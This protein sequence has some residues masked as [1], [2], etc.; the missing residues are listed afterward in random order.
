MSTVFMHFLKKILFA[1]I[2]INNYPLKIFILHKKMH[3]NA[4]KHQSYFL[5]II[6]EEQL[7]ETR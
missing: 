7:N 3:L 4:E 2:F 5:E 6:S 1:T